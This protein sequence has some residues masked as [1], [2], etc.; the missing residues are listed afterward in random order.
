MGAMRLLFSLPGLLPRIT[1]AKEHWSCASRRTPA[2]RLR[3]TDAARSTPRIGGLRTRPRVSKP[4]ACTRM[5]LPS[6][7]G[8]GDLYT[9]QAVGRT[10]GWA[11]RRG[12]TY[13]CTPPSHSRVASSHSPSTW[14]GQGMRGGRSNLGWPGGGLG[15]LDDPSF[16]PEST[17]VAPRTNRFQNCPRPRRDLARRSQRARGKHTHTTHAKDAE[18]ADRP[19]RADASCL[20]FR[21]ILQKK[22]LLCPKGYR[23]DTCCRVYAAPWCT[24]YA[25]ACASKPVRV[26]LHSVNLVPR[27]EQPLAIHPHL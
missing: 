24:Q 14:E 23:Y 26:L 3:V 27:D 15:D 2:P 5:R 21:H 18:D 17:L 4:A 12:S 20:S 22:T 6:R 7:R 1:Q 8:V 16:W 10:A 11:N 19:Q 25:C 9:G 13:A